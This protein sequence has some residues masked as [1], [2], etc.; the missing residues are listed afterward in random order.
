MTSRLVRS[1][2]II[3]LFLAAAFLGTASGVIFAFLGDSPQISA[4]DDYSLS[5]ITRVYGRDGTLVG[6]FATERRT[7]VTSDQ[8]P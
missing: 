3:A 6:D 5:T 2:G 8:I 4:L 1:F 7:V